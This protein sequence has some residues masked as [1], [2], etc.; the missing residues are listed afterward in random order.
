M[1]IHTTLLILPSVEFV[2]KVRCSI[3]NFPYW[4]IF[5]YWLIFRILGDIPGTISVQLFI[6]ESPWNISHGMVFKKCVFPFS[7]LKLY[8][9]RSRMSFLR[10]LLLTLQPLH[11]HCLPD[12]LHSTP[13]MGWSSW[14][15][16]FSYNSEEKMIAQ[17]QNDHFNPNYKQ[18]W[19]FSQ[20]NAIFCIIWNFT[21]D[22]FLFV[23]DYFWSS[24]DWTCPK[25]KS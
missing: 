3:N 10:F 12:G 1:S 16:F 25:I 17:V 13:P 18:I 20:G 9:S 21:N 6:F 2:P 19:Q 22:S 14:N 23:C 8:S 7:N 24:Q 4:V 5:W 15:T 11:R